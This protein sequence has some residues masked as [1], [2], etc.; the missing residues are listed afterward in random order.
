M[1][2]SKAQID[3]LKEAFIA[4]EYLTSEMLSYLSEKLNIEQR[5]ILSWFKNKRIEEYTTHKK[6]WG[7]YL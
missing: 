3:K 6:F 5:K 1:S 4:N 2:F 7:E